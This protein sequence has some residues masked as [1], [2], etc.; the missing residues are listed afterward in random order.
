MFFEC[1]SSHIW[2]FFFASAATATEIKIAKELGWSIYKRVL[3]K[4]ADA[5]NGVSR[6]PQ[7]FNERGTEV[8]TSRLRDSVGK[9][10]VL[11][12]LSHFLTHFICLVS[13]SKHRI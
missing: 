11:C 4:L 1:P 6:N 12:M 9:Y 7:R 3:Q 5:L 8:Q 10:T 2:A 13:S